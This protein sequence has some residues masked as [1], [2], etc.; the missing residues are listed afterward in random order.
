MAELRSVD[1]QSLIPNPNNPRRTAA[2]KAMDEQLLASIRA[3]GI[4][5]PPRVTETPDGLMVVA[6]NRRRA[7]AIAAGLA[8]IHVMVCDA[9][10]AA[11]AMRAVSENLI[12]ASMTSVD[13]WRATDSL[14]RQGWNEQ[15]SAGVADTGPD[16][17]ANDDAEPCAPAAE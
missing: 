1:P 14:E 15:A 9:D 17:P 10:E 8:E 2:P 16:Q 13:I 3:V 6:G 11:D 12:R 5:Q 4:I 7:A